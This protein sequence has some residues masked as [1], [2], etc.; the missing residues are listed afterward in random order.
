MHQQS[1]LVLKW[2]RVLR[3]GFSRG[4]NAPAIPMGPKVGVLRK[5]FSRGDNAPAIPVGKK[6]YL[7]VFKWG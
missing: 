3:K 2:V 6:Q 4:T 7:W 1:L 5:G